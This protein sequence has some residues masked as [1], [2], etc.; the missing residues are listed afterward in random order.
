MKC[1]AGGDEEEECLDLSELVAILIIPYLVKAAKIILTSTEKRK[2]EVEKKRPQ[3]FDNQFEYLDYI[4][5]KTI[6]DKLKPEN[7]NIVKDMLSII[8]F[9]ATGCADSAKL[10]AQLLKDIFYSFGED[11]LAEDDKLIQDMIIAAGGNVDGTGDDDVILNTDT[12]IR[13]LT[14]DVDKYDEMNEIKL[15]T[16]FQDVFGVDNQSYELVNSQVMKCVDD[17]ERGSTKERVNFNIVF[18]ASAID[19]QADTYMSSTISIVLW[20]NFLVT[21]FAYFF[22]ATVTLW[23]KDCSTLKHPFPCYLNNALVLWTI[24]WIKLT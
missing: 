18:S 6:L 19:T 5:T 1:F 4:E 23:L 12:F 7:P 21:Y 17:E 14:A 10:N 20:I 16:F 2:R 24:N 9:E 15:T 22:S 3:D 11:D 13:A 8:L